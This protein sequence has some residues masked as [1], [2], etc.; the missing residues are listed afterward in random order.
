[1]NN[2]ALKKL[3]EKYL[4][5]PIILGILGQMQSTYLNAVPMIDMNT[6]RFIYS[7]DVNNMIAELK[8]QLN[9]YSSVKYADLFDAL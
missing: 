8:K 5:D 4:N 6:D 9:D 7:D 3:Q 2:E 1:M